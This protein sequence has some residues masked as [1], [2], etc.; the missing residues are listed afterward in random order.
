MIDDHFRRF[1]K[2]CKA[3]AYLASRRSKLDLILE[4]DNAPSQ[5]NSEGITPASVWP[6]S[7]FSSNSDFSQ[8][9]TA[10]HHGTAAR[11]VLRFDNRKVAR[12]NHSPSIPS[13]PREDVKIDIPLRPVDSDV[14][15]ENGDSEG[16]SGESNREGSDEVDHPRSSLHPRPVRTRYQNHRLK[17]PP[18]PWSSTVHERNPLDEGSRDQSY[19][20][21]TPSYEHRGYHPMYLGYSGSNV[22][23]TRFSPMP[24]YGPDQ[25]FNTTLHPSESP[26]LQSAYTST[27]KSAFQNSYQSYRPPFLQPSLPPPRPRTS[28]KLSSTPVKPP[29]S[30]PALPEVKPSPIS[31]QL[32]SATVAQEISDSLQDINHIAAVDAFVEKLKKK[33]EQR[34]IDA[35]RVLTYIDQRSR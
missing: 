14:Q 34:M 15:A 29:Q 22:P 5:S 32:P 11:K 17:P 1:C 31:P 6:L 23:F 2:T 20:R 27:G 12:T 30:P 10:V 7:I 19:N 25:Y 9:T 21:R 35:H 4:E 33:N 26:Y 24:Y 28:P 18:D 8:A 16:T 13:P 3:N